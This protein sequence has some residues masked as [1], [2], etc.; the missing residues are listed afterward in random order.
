MR[1]YNS[2]KA[3][4]AQKRFVE[5]NR[6]KVNAYRRKRYAENTE[7]LRAQKNSYQSASP[8]AKKARALKRKYGLTI[9][10]WK[11]LFA[12]QRGLCPICGA[13]LQD[14][15]DTVVDHDHITNKVRGLLCR[16]CNC[17]IGLLQ[18]SVTILERATRYVAGY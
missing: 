6:D 9:E 16:K 17:G 8:E 15:V 1:V 5:K 10:Q 11:A 18:D 14:D 4:A 13:I 2:K 3:V 7:R 12:A